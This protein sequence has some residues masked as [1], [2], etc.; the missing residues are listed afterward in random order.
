MAAQ[1]AALKKESDYEN[2]LA[3]LGK[4]LADAEADVIRA[5]SSAAEAKEECEAA[6]ST[7]V[8]VETKAAKKESE[9]EAKL[10]EVKRLANVE[11]Q[12]R[13]AELAL[14]KTRYKQ[15]I[16]LVAQQ[17]NSKTAK[18]AETAA[19]DKAKAADLYKVRGKFPL[20]MLIDDASLT[21]ADFC[22]RRML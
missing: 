4:Q 15:E 18:L 12:S 21:I 2:E 22:R 19:I 10:A 8:D 14:E 13:T 7:M 1:A 20:Q 3:S 16:E 17:L 6:H 9:Y 5:E 11:M